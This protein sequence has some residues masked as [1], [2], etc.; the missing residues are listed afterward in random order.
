MSVWLPV[1]LS[2]SPVLSVV[3]LLSSFLLSCRAA[4]LGVPALLGFHAPPPSV[5]FWLARWPAGCLVASAGGGVLRAP[6]QSATGNNRLCGERFPA[7]FPGRAAISVFCLRVCSDFELA[8]PLHLL[9]PPLAVLCPIG[10]GVGF[11]DD[12]FLPHRLPI[13]RLYSQIEKMRYKP[14]PHAVAQG[15]S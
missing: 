14:M 15:P 1:C 7:T 6:L 13:W 9:F 3:F 2:V 10:L 4:V 12:V 8:S 5:G 11:F